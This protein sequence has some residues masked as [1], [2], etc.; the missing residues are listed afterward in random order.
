MANVYR[1]PQDYATIT[2]A[3]AAA[4][5]LDTVK[6]AAGIYH[7]TVIINKRIQLLGAQS[8]IDA[9]ERSGSLIAETVISQ[10]ANQGAIQITADD[11]I[12]DGITVQDNT[13]GAGIYS[14]ATHSGYWIINTIVQ[15][16]AYGI[17]LNSNGQKTV[18]VRQN[19]FYSNNINNAAGNGIFSILGISNV[20]IDSNRFSGMHASATVNFG[21]PTVQNNITILN[22]EFL[23]DNSI[24]LTNT[25]NVKVASNRFN[26]SSGTSVY[27]GGATNNTVLEGNRFE[28]GMGYAI[29]VTRSFNAALNL[30]LKI[31]GNSI[32]GNALAGMYVEAGAYNPTGPNSRLDA[33]NNWWG[34]ASGPAPSGSGDAIVDPDNVSEHIPFLTAN[35]FPVPDPTISKVLSTGVIHCAQGE[36]YNMV[37]DILNDDITTAAGI[38]MWG[39]FLVPDNPK[40]PF[41]FEPIQVGANGYT[42]RSLVTYFGDRFEFQFKITNTDDVIITIWGMHADGTLTAIQRLHAADFVPIASQ[43]PTS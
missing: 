32:A 13:A 37:I 6:V 42:Q 17:Y 23:N 1:V 14:N 20:L 38:E 40:I 4:S 18:Q 25:N 19:M 26:N 35:P 3:I 12:I 31:V 24:A 29:Q 21:A 43:T 36:P 16:N 30:N 7:E 15:N 8:G 22:N 34:S 33:T 2:A 28:N 11:V 39:F 10:S 5:D 27:L 41:A 9:R